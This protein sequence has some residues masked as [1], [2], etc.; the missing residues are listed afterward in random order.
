MSKERVLW[1]VFYLLLLMGVYYLWYVV[2]EALQR[3]TTYIRDERSELADV[4][5]TKE[6][7]WERRAR[8]EEHLLDLKIAEAERHVQR[9][10]EKDERKAKS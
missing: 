4:V 9:S 2:D 3:P 8:K 5:K 10:Y 7:P 1:F 6:K